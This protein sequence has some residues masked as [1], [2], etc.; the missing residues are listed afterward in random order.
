VPLPYP[1]SR[2]Q[3]SKIAEVER[4]RYRQGLG[5]ACGTGR[6]EVMGT[7]AFCESSIRRG[8]RYP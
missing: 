6:T 5:S 4:K 1:P 2:K 7:R 8:R 3:R